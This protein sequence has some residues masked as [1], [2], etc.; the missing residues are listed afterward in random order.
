MAAQREA[1]K[2]RTSADPQDLHDVV[3]AAWPEAQFPVGPLSTPQIGDQTREAA[4]A[5]QLPRRCAYR[6]AREDA[7]PQAGQGVTNPQ[8]GT[9]RP[10]HIVRHPVPSATYGMASGARALRCQ[11]LQ[12]SRRPGTRNRLHG[13][14]GV[15]E[16]PRRREAGFPWTGRKG[17][18]D[19]NRRPAPEHDPRPRSP[20]APTGGRLSPTLS[21]RCVPAIVRQA[22][23]KPGRDAPRNSGRNRRWHGTQEDRPRERSHALR[24]V[25][26]A[27]SQARLESHA[28]RWQT[29]TRHA[30]LVATGGAR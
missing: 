10:P 1:K 2:G 29:T 24:T 16:A 4:G 8:N 11:S 28:S 6:R 9:Q 19:A 27:S 14:R 25:A 5:K 15:Q 18:R 23:S 30:R 12:R 26:G 22:V 21:P 3:Q 13:H 17:T 7:P 20:S